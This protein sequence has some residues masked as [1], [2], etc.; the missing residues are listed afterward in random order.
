M[1]QHPRLAIG[2]IFLHVTR[3]SH[4]TY[5]NCGSIIVQTHTQAYSP[6]METKLNQNLLSAAKV[7]MMERTREDAKLKKKK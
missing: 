4:Y 6:P 3:E 1:A 7:E 2:L 5:R